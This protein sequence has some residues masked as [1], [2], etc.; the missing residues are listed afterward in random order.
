M[1]IPSDVITIVAG[2]MNDSSQSLYTNSVCLPFLNLALNELQE[3]FE[4]NGIPITNETSAVITLPAGSAQLGFTTTPAL[5]ADLIEIQ[6]LWE[7]PT[8]LNK[9]TRID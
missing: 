7:S 9:W 6:Q 8:G 1:P 3:L 4:L 5:P 2:L